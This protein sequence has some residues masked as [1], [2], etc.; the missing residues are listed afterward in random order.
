MQGISKI[1]PG[2]KALSDVNFSVDFG[3]VHAIVGENGA[4]KSTLMKVL[5]GT[6]LPTTG[7]TEVG[8]VEVR[9]RKPA[10]AQKLGIRMVHQELNLVPD[11]TVAENVHLGRM[12]RK[13]LLVDKAA[14]VGNAAAVLK[15][16]GADIDPKARLGDLSISQ[17]Q[18][19]EIAKAYAA[20]P[21]IIVLDEPTSSLS[22]HETAALFRI[23]RKMKAQGIAIVYISHRLKEVLEI[24]DDVTILRDGSMIE[25]RPA[26]G[27]TAAQMIKLMVG[28]EVTN[29]FPKTPSTIGA[30]VLKVRGLGDGV[31]FSN[32]SFDVRAGEILGLTG[33][34][35]AGRTE[36]AKAIFGLS[37]LT[38]GSI[39]THGK[40][41]TI[42][43][44]SQAMRAGIAYVPEDRKGD[45]IIPSMT[46]R[47]N[48]SLPVLRRLSRFSRVS[49]SAD[50]KLAAKYAADFSIV[51][52]DPER[53]INL[54][55]GGNQQKAVISKWLSAKPSVLILDEPTRG[56]DVGAKAEIHRII[57][58]LVAKGMAVVMISSELPEVLGVCDRVV[59]MRDGR[60][61]PA[62]ERKDLSEERIMALATGEE[63]A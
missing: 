57:G 25:S 28:R 10:D 39:E 42:R 2:V 46:V 33:L 32:V 55:S 30:P 54:L 14:M 4:G 60:A 5:S 58:E 29:V 56:V 47:E 40:P 52:P 38:A 8:G 53:R 36:V 17:Q 61:S 11:L 41:V 50:R 26:D 63:T 24:A 9:M 6:Y 23:L 15:E 59:V 43:S 44:P 62:I 35:G 22:E 49:L 19:V 12:P 51:P 34:V 16:L 7:T 1:F 31:T 13:W 21:R 45:G 37:T 18:L 20:N 3:R 48:I 27:I